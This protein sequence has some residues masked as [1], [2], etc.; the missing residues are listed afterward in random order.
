MRSFKPTDPRIIDVQQAMAS[1]EK[2]VGSFQNVTPDGVG[3]QGTMMQRWCMI[4]TLKGKGKRQV[5]APVQVHQPLATGSVD[6]DIVQVVGGAVTHG[7]GYSHKGGTVKLYN[8][9]T[10]FLAIEDWLAGMDS[11]E[12]ARKYIQ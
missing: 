7:S 9:Y 2:T 4:A 6:T 8:M 3:V 10:R 11:G 1:L 12:I 5:G